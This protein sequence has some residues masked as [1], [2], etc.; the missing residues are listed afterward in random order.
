MCYAGYDIFT[1]QMAD[2]IHFRSS[3]EL[4]EA[5]H[6]EVKRLRAEGLPRKIANKSAVARTLLIMSLGDDQQTAVAQEVLRRVWSVCQSITNQVVARGM[7]AFPE[8]LEQE[9]DALEGDEA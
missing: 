9:L 5:I 8:L 7:E 1:P 2:F 3:P 6:N 4:E